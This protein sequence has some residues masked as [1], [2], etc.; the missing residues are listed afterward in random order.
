MRSHFGTFQIILLRLVSPYLLGITSCLF[1]LNTGS[2]YTLYNE[3]HWLYLLSLPYTINGMHS[4][5][6]TVLDIL[7][8]TTLVA[9]A[10][11]FSYRWERGRLPYPP[12]PRG[13]PI[14]GHFLTFPK[15]FV[16][17]TFTKWGQQYGRTY[18]LPICRELMVGA[19]RGCHVRY[20]PGTG[21]N[22]SQ[23]AEDSQ[24]LA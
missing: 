5:L 3:L 6:I 7:A 10:T 1:F 21:D 15:N 11:S 2:P 20:N 16:W 12:G 17:L 24:G 13:L 4:S 23:L 19:Y 14:I 18:P 8:A 9:L 22:H